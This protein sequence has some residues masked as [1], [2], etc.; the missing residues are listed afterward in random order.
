MKSSLTPVSSNV[1]QKKSTNK[2]V[3]INEP[4]TKGVEETKGSSS[5]QPVGKSK[6]LLV[7]KKD[8]EQQ[9]KQKKN[10]NFLPLQ[11][12]AW[13]WNSERRDGN[14]TAFSIPFPRR[15]QRTKEFCFISASAGKHHGLFIT[16]TGN[17]YSIGDGRQGQLGYGNIFTGLP[18]K[19]GETQATPRHVTPSGLLKFGHDLQS[20]EV[21]AGGSFSMS[22]EINHLEA[23]KIVKGFLSLEA[24][25][26]Y[27]LQ[28]FPD[29]QAI[30]HAYSQIRQERCV[31]NRRAEGKVLVWGT[32]KHGELGLG[33]DQNYTPYPILNYTLNRVIVRQIAAGPNHCL[34]ITT[35]GYLYSWGVGKCGRLG[36][37]DFE[38]RHVPEIVQFTLSM[39]VVYCAAGDAHSAVL[40]MPR[41]DPFAISQQPLSMIHAKSIYAQGEDAY[42]NMLTGI[43][44]KI[45]CFG[46]GAHGRLGN[47][48]NRNSSLPVLVRTFPPSVQDAQI[49]ALSC[50][51]AHTLALL[52]KRCPASLV[53]P[54]GIQSFVLSWGY[55]RNGQLGTGYDDDCFTPMKVRIPKHEIVLQVIDYHSIYFIR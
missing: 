34:A 55:G 47:G 12:A 42:K 9:E 3:T 44:R 23:S 2:K 1:G 32:G 36:H 40:T 21:A 33:T 50:G 29:S 25:I 37:G 14:L 11:A 19:G 31:I 30:R 45:L 51:G 20:V 4:K 41:D 52:H 24:V 46:R 22:R 5:E 6:F 13:G 48:T 7:S 16:N 35:E 27:Y 49:V 38:D 26:S 28:L 18:A 54:N 10:K 15:L 43:T 53:Y 17:I 39:H 8:E